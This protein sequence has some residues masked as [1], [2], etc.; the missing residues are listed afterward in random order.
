MF[1]YASEDERA[2]LRAYADLQPQ[3]Y[4][5]SP[6]QQAALDAVQ[7]ALRSLDAVVLQGETGSGKT[8]ILNTLASASRSAIT[9]LAQFFEL[10]KIRNPL[11]IEEA[12]IETLENALDGAKMVVVDDLHMIQRVVGRYEYPR[13]Q[14]FEAALKQ[15]TER[16]TRLGKK[17]VFAVDGDGAPSVLACR[18]LPIRIG[19]FNAAD[20]QVICAAHLTA[21][22]QVDFDAVQRFAPKLNA[23]QLRIASISLAGDRTLSTDSFIAF[24]SSRNMASNVDLEEVP[25]VDWKQLKGIDSLIQALETK[26]AFP[27]ENADISAEFGLKPKRGVLLAGPPGT[28]K[29]TIGRAL[30]HRLKSK[31]FLVDGTVVAGS[32][33]FYCE[34]DSI[35]EAARRNAPSIIF[36]DDADVIFEDNNDS[37]FY[38]YLLTMLDGLKSASASQ[39]CVMMTAMEVSSLPPALVRSGRIELWLETRLPDQ[40][41]RETILRENLSTSPEPIRSADAD[42]LARAS[43]GLSGA[44]LK[45]VLEDGKLE[46]AYG[47]ATQAPACAVEEYFLRAIRTIKANRRIYGRKR[48]RPF[49]AETQFGFERVARA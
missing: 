44:D 35:F 42:C 16:A 36:I 20:Y 34:I 25:P 28:G 15:F 32:G 18:A 26:V 12:F 24:L 13:Q 8:L 22:S 5:L 48:S 27:F 31:F 43:S 30:A 21:P 19:A 29:T 3:P 11:A 14:M 2:V 17:L 49:G 6:V 47:L 23:H 39:V 4:A 40:S 46:L 41:A 33:D 9:G 37:G 45:S 1:T 38:R 7:T 10:L